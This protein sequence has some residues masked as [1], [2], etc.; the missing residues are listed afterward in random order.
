LFRP[1]FNADNNFA[2]DTQIVCYPDV[3]R[4]QVSVSSKSDLIG[5]GVNFVKNLCCDP[6][7]RVDLLLGYRYINLNDEVVINENLTALG[8][9]RGTPPG[10]RFLIEDKFRTENHFHGGV[11]GINAERRFSHF[12]VNLR[13]SVALGV[14]RQ[15]T[16]I[17][18]ATRIITPAPN[19]TDTT[20][21]GGLLTQPSNIGTY[22]QNKFCVVPEVG[23]K[24]GVQLT[25]HT[26]LFVGYNYLYMSSVQRAGNQIDLR[27]NAQQIA[28]ATGTGQFPTFLNNT[29]G[30]SAHGVSAG[31][32]FRF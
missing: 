28:P 23:L 3:L 6:C 4:G 26:R 5:G 30:F 18:G 2:P 10:T 22:T 20:Y 7:G 24:V 1:F 8:Q 12:Y 25:E 13:S 11:I 29:S 19:A 32:E 16:T 9:V 31:V 15:T 27:V 14:N 17:S 21:P